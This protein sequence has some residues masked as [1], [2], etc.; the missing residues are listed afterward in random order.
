MINSADTFTP[1]RSFL[2]LGMCLLTGM[3]AALMWGCGGGGSNNNSGP[4]QFTIASGNWVIPLRSSNLSASFPTAGGSLTQSGNSI[5]GIL[6]ISGSPCFDPVNDPLTVHGT[7]SG[8]PNAANA[9]TVTTS[10]VRGQT[11]SVSATW[12]RLLNPALPPP[13][14][15]PNPVTSLSGSWTISGGACAGTET[16]P[17]LFQLGDFSGTWG[18]N[19]DGP[20]WSGRVTAVLSQTAPDAQGLSHLSGTFSVSGSPCFTSGTIAN[21]AFAGDINQMTVVMDSGQLTGSTQISTTFMGG[22][23]FNHLSSSFVVH[24]GSCDGQSVNFSSVP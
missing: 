6:Y 12:N 14:S 21:T 9:L 1:S 24:G 8:D 20:S 23:A 7:V 3:L 17:W 2:R 13:T 18:G 5:S 11:L 4:P 10:A 22:L 19:L 16:G 15:P